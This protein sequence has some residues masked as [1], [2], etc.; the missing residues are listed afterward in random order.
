MNINKLIVQKVAE[1]KSL[2]QKI[3]SMRKTTG[4]A[5]NVVYYISEDVE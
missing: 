2:L 1:G 4:M 3:G 5:I